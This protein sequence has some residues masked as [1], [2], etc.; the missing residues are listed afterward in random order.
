MLR[1]EFA[2]TPFGLTARENIRVSFALLA[3]TS[4]PTLIA[5]LPVLVTAVW[6][7]IT[8]GYVLPEDGMLKV[9]VSDQSTAPDV[10]LVASPGKKIVIMAGPEK[11]YQGPVIATPYLEKRQWWNDLVE[12]PAG[13]LISNSPVEQVAL[14]VRRRMVW[15]GMANW[16]A[17]W[18]AP[19]FMFVF[20]AALF[21]KFQYRID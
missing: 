10:R 15:V 19:F 11:I 3:R 4:G 7:D 2:Q 8:H 13:Y 5:A 20:A 6:V 18:E 1:P 17:G 21:L 16:A 14:N 9:L 12:A